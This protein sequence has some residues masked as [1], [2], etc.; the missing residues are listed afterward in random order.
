MEQLQGQV[1][2]VIYYNQDNG[3][4]V[5]ELTSGDEETVC[6]GTTGG[7]NPGEYV[8][9]TGEYTQ[10]PVYGL[11]L[12]VRELT[13]AVPED[14]EAIA[15][16]LGSGAVKGIRKALAARIV[17]RFGKDT[18]RIMDEEPERLAEIKGI[19]E[20]KAGEIYASFH[21][22][23]GARQAIM[24]LAKY[25]I[26]AVMAIRIYNQYKDDTVRIVRENPYKL[27]EDINGI[28]FGTAD[29]IARKAGFEQDSPFRI[30]SGII[31]VL[32]SAAG[33]GHTCL[34]EEEL[35]AQAADLLGVAEEAVEDEL[36]GLMMDR[37]IKVKRGQVFL[38][39]IYRIELE[40]A[41]LLCG[42]DR[43]TK[44]DERE[45]ERTIA[46]VEKEEKID[47]DEMQRTA[48]REAARRGVL[49][50]T[51]GPG[52]GKTTIIKTVIKYLE[53]SGMEVLLAAPTGR[54]AKRMTEATG[55][56]AK[57]VHRLLEV[58]GGPEQDSAAGLGASSGSAGSFGGRFGRNEDTPLEA[59]AVIID[60]T[61]MVDIFLMNS[62]L[63]AIPA[64]TKLILVG[65]ASQ[66]PS[67]GPGN[68]LRDIIDSGAFRCVQLT[69]IFRQALESDII[70][71][72]HLI[73]EGLEIRLDNKSKDFLCVKRKTAPDILGVTVLL[74][75][76]KLPGY[77]GVRP[78]DIQVLTPMRKGELGVENLNKVLQYYLNPAAPDKHEKEFH[79]GILRE[80]DKVMQIRNDYQL[81]WE[82][83]GRFGIPVDSGTGVFNGD[84]GKVK[85]I[86]SFAE[87][88]SVEFDEGRIV[89][90]TYSQLDELELAYAVTVHK[91]QGSEYPGVILPILA[92]P[93]ML[94]NRN[95][96][97]TAVTRAVKCV[98]IVGDEDTVQ[99]MIRNES[100]NRR[101]SA[102]CGMIR[103]S[104]AAQSLLESFE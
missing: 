37:K 67:V 44:A 1:T 62:L 79:G 65:D 52:T 9:V 16:Y 78:E 42:L 21:E 46:R 38:S 81:E 99:Q 49:I 85:E 5:F 63:K 23:Q 6:T 77:L 39:Y 13:Y 32:Q 87:T 34:P 74:I 22:S 101:H 51:G 31:Y 19:S 56:E 72:A 35:T 27:A 14:E 43:D 92:G 58:S 93:R 4:T 97:Y 89:E 57:T 70:K 26:S 71:N 40:T 68:V 60:E 55:M 103:D 36:A 8:S 7:I 73:N 88:V 86:N 20:R 83:R 47:L 30:R 15:L 76:D 28:G 64:G 3:Y 82:V 94:M 90:Y 54:A 25:N 33:A 2:G 61:S 100:Q 75:R 53:Y 17:K 84:A 80:G 12:K 96:L 11:Q 91:S 48:V 95:I 66:L 45:L 24:L 41:E 102:L 104:G 69:R 98:M 10:H 18:L 59:D 29:E 50:V